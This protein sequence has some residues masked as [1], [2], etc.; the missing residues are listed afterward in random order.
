[1]TKNFDTLLEQMLSEMMPADIEGLGFGGAKEV[2]TKAIPKGEPKG[3]W[4]PLQKLLES[5][6]KIDKIYDAILKTVF[7]EKD[8]TLNPDADNIKD[9]A[10]YF[11]D[12]VVAASKV[13][14]EL[15]KVTSEA[16]PPW[17]A[18]FLKDRLV[19]ALK[20]QINFTTAGGEAPVKKDVT[21]KEFKQKLNQALERLSAEVQI[22]IDRL[23]DKLD[24]EIEYNIEEFAQMMH[25]DNPDLDETETKQFAEYAI[26]S[27]RLEKVGKNAYKLASEK[28]A[29]QEEMEG[30][31]EVTTGIE[32][33]D[34]DPFS[35]DGEF[36]RTFSG[37]DSDF[38]SNY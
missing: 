18:K 11:L 7:P 1:M 36:N 2:L 14:P 27:D 33:D 19:S 21:Q 34:L 13:V 22:K 23:I 10:P 9:L 5:P 15:G 8:N 25:E 28:E 6:E 12:G 26:K 3:H 37:Y 20:D 24:P 29:E 35:F 30:S 32:D 31:G 38:S 17:W 4:K 16:N